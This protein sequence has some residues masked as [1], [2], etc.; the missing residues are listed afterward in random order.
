[1][2]LENSSIT[3][4][5]NSIYGERRQQRMKKSDHESRKLLFVMIANKL[6]L[7]IKSHYFHIISCIGCKSIMPLVT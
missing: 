5:N 7:N 4:Q 1:M 3:E 6:M 2:Q